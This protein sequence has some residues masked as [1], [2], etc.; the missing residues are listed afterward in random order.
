METVV[1]VEDHVLLSGTEL[2]VALDDLVD[3]VHQVFLSDGLSSGADGEHAGLGT[4]RTDVCTG[5]VR[6]HSRNQLKS[7]V[8]IESHSFGMNFKDLHSSLKIWQAELDLSIKTTGSGQCG[9]EG[10]RSIGCHENL[11]I[12]S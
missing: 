12:A 3:G 1:S 5:R 8:L 6:A 4:D 10:V 11:H 9:I 7:N 2:R